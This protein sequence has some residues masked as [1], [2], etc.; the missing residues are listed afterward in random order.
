MKFIQV[1]EKIGLAVAHAVELPFSYGGKIV[2][3]VKSAEDDAP[4]IIAAFDGLV[5][6]GSVVG[7]DTALEVSADG[8]N[9]PEYLVVAK[10]S[11]AFAAYFKNVFLPT[12]EQLFNDVKTDVGAGA[13]SGSGAAPPAAPA[14][15]ATSG[16][17]L[18]PA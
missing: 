2:A 18:A 6:A 17:A 16:G 3:L 7:V 15:A 12:I 8:T 10:D 11:V 5:K 13:P 9:L 1:I 4:A 14:P